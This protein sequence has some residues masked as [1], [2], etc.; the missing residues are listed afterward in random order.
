MI[1]KILEYAQIP[2]AVLEDLKNMRNRNPLAGHG[3]ENTNAV[4][5]EIGKNLIV[6]YILDMYNV[7]TGKVVITEQLKLS[8]GSDYGKEL[9]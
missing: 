3:A 9:K 2:Q 6:D 7:A 8:E 4:F 5:V 1:R